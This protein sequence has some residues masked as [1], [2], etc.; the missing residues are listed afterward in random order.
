MYSE[1]DIFEKPP[2]KCQWCNKMKPDVRYADLVERMICSD[3]MGVDPY[4]I[5]A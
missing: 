4:T 5:D 2:T 1:L 3:C